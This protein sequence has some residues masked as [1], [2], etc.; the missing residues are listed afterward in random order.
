[1]NITEFL[2]ARIDEDEAVA[3]LIP[4]AYTEH[5]GD[6]LGTLCEGCGH[7]MHSS[8]DCDHDCGDDGISGCCGA[9]TALPPMHVRVLADCEAKR[10]IVE[11]ANALLVDTCDLQHSCEAEDILSAL[12]LPYADHPDYDEAWRP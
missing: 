5:A 10:R 1:M 11:T 8:E 6:C 3:K 12:A 4:D 2:K 7:C 9:M